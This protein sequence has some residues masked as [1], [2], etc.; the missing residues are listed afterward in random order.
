M[1]HVGRGVEQAVDP[2]PAVG[3]HHAE[4]GRRR[5]LLDH[6]PDLAVLLAGAD[7]RDGLLQALVRHLEHV[8]R[9]FSREWSGRG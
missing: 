6:V 4:P 2:V 3:A 7:D 9:T 8:T 5:V 1:R